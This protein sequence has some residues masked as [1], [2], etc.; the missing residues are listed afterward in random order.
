MCYLNMKKTSVSKIKQTSI[1]YEDATL[2]KSEY[3]TALKN[4]DLDNIVDRHEFYTTTVSHL[5]S[6]LRKLI[7]TE[8]KKNRKYYKN[9]WRILVIP[10]NFSHEPDS[11]SLEDLV[12][13]YCTFNSTGSILKNLE[14]FSLMSEFF[15][16]FYPNK[17]DFE[18][19]DAIYNPD[20]RN[21]VSH[22][23]RIPVT[24]KKLREIQ[25]NID[26][27]FDKLIAVYGESLSCGITINRYDSQTADTKIQE[28][29]KEQK[30]R[31]KDLPWLIDKKVRKSKI[32]KEEFLEHYD[33]LKL[34]FRA[35]T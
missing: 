17:V 19:L 35:L 6:H 25:D 22:P 24:T 31:V 1:E 23:G 10:G 32:S 5:E 8:I 13:S 2:K 26:G 30:M 16:W 9:I 3:L 14:N 28:I 4:K 34:L 11:S 15:K 12:L 20:H 18:N 21:N 33:N 27:F 29:I 7:A